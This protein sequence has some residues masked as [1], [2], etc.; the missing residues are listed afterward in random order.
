MLTGIGRIEPEKGAG[1]SRRPARAP[2]F[3]VSG[4]SSAAAP[5]PAHTASVSATDLMPLL[6]LQA[7][8]DDIARNRRACERAEALLGELAALQAALLA[9]RVDVTKLERLAALAAAPSEARDPSLAGIADWVIL[10]AQVMLARLN[11]R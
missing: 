5:Q 11:R 4:A 2:G 3:V 10:R 8:D 6:A 1:R 7:D 9:G